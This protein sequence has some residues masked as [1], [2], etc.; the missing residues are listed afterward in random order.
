MIGFVGR[1]N[2]QRSISFNRGYER[3]CKKKDLNV[4]AYF[5]GSVKWIIN[6]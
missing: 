2:E 4:K 6:I 5:V 1:I 3:T